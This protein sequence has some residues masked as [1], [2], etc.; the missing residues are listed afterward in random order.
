MGQINRS[1]WA[2]RWVGSIGMMVALAGGAHGAEGTE[3]AFPQYPA[4]NPDGSLISFS[5][6]GDIWAVPSDGGVATRLTGHPAL[7]ERSAFSPDGRT[8]A[9]ESNRDGTQQIYAVDLSAT[10]GGVP[11]AGTVERVTWGDRSSSL[12]GFTAD[13]TGVTFASFREPTV[14]RSP[15]MYRA[16]LDGGPVTRLTDAYGSS[17]RMGADGSVVFERGYNPWYRPMYRG[18]GGRDAWKLSADGTFTQ[19]TANPTNDGDA[20]VLPDGSVLFVSSRDGQNNVYRLRAGVTDANAR[21]VTQLT[22]FSPGGEA[23]IGHGVRDLAVSADGSRAVFAVWDTL[24]TLD[25]RNANAQPIAVE[26]RGSADADVG[27]VKKIDLSSE[28][29]EAVLSPDGTALAVVARGEVLVRGTDEDRPTRR[30][31]ATNA[32]EGGLAWS[33]DG[34]ALYFVADPDGVDQLFTA[35]VDLSRAD[36]M[37]EAQKEREAEEAAEEEASTTDDNAV[38]SDDTEDAEPESDGVDAGDDA[39][40]GDEAADEKADEDEG[41]EEGERWATGLRFSVEPLLSDEQALSNPVPSPDGTKLL[42]TRG[43]GDLMM[44][45]LRTGETSVLEEGWS[46]P[47]YSWASDSV[48]VVYAREDLDFNSDVFILDTRCDGGSCE[49][50]NVTR[51]PDID[52]SPMLSHDGKV[53]IFLSD[54]DSTNWSMDVYR[55]FLD[56]DLEE[57]AGYELDAYFEEQAKAA[58]KLEPA[59]PLGDDEDGSEDADAGDREVLEFDLDDAH[60]SVR[61]LTTIPAGEGGL[62]IT[63]AADR[64]VFT[65]TID[66]DRGLYSVDFRG[67]DRKTLTTGAVQWVSMSLTGDQVVY[68]KG[69]RAAS[70]KPGGGSATSMPVSANIAVDMSGEQ[71]QKFREAARRFGDGFYHPTLKGV[72]WA[73]A[74]A[75][76]EDLASRTRTSAAFNRLGNMLFG[77]VDGSHT[78]M[79]G[80]PGYSAPSERVGYLG[81]EAVP[82]AGGYRVTRVMDDGPA[83]R[84]DEGLKVGDLIVAVNA[85]RLASDEAD[86]GVIDLAWAMTGTLGQETLVEVMRGDAGPANAEG[87]GP[88]LETAYLVLTP[89][90]FGAENTLG[91]RHEV[92]RRRAQVERLSDGRLGYL[93]IRGMSEPSVREFERDLYAAADGREGLVIDVRDNGGGW[94][95]DILL[96]SLTAPQ[97]AY[98][99]P[100]GADMEDVSTYHYPRGRRLIYAYQRPINVLINANSFSNAEIFAHSIK[101]IGR[102]TLVG[103]QTFGGVIS[104]GGFRLIDG[105]TVRM[106]FRGWFLPDGTDMEHH[107]AMPDVD[108][109][110][111]PGDEASGD[112]PQL[113]AAVDELLGRLDTRADAR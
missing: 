34:S 73:G 22:R 6:A 56:R 63:P 80:G 111:T 84:G 93:H 31:T 13:G 44:L 71:R 74:S 86:A 85:T 87:D 38:A 68:V 104:T 36:I 18:P 96:A 35:R 78:G 99:I 49:P 10:G 61:R 14:F 51:H 41:P 106:P 40:D 83:D 77:E 102:G 19:L 75:R 1:G 92:A 67:D 55:V 4:L 110:Q 9:F 72:D 28:V 3:I 15:R 81:I 97:H 60:M 23:T 45:D 70:V 20:S 82:E 29:T 52:G 58:K 54:R 65:S 50:V 101:T 57:M 33:A 8:L 76:Y 47:D 24:Y 11:V 7:E 69:G 107:G 53:L 59:E 112:D 5:W 64:I 37:H 21:A 90:S 95:T 42:Y 105:T 62:L 103:E 27:D 113:E 109:V 88:G 89:H 26:M 2:S 30:V 32:R 46:E 66:G 108:V 16:P 100:R 91:Y 25:L 94:T 39:G 17:P 43:L 48:H 98:T 79:R 12:G